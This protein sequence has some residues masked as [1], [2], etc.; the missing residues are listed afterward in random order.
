MSELVREVKVIQIF[1][2]CERCGGL[3]EY[4]NVNG[5][6]LLTNPPLYP[7]VCNNCG[8]KSNYHKIYPYL[9]SI[10]VENLREPT[11]EERKYIND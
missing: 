5:N 7:H 6:A 3:M 11:G 10:P 2:T 8:M 1:K 9:E 4:D